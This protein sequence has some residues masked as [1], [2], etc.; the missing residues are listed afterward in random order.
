MSFGVFSFGGQAKLCRSA[1]FQELGWIYTNKLVQLKG[2]SFFR[3]HELLEGTWAC[4]IS[5]GPLCSS[6]HFSPVIL[7]CI[8]LKKSELRVFPHCKCCPKRMNENNKGSTQCIMK[9][10]RLEPV[11]VVIIMYSLIVLVLTEFTVAEVLYLI[12][13]LP[14]FTQTHCIMAEI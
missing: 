5:L 12:L 2:Q 9:Y 1:D 7:L 10:N 14:A 4:S 13:V 11:V 3:E 6:A 8:I